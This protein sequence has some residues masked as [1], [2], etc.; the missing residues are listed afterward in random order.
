MATYSS[1]P[2]M[3][4]MNMMAETGLEKYS[5]AWMAEAK[6]LAIKLAEQIRDELLSFTHYDEPAHPEVTFIDRP[7][8]VCIVAKDHLGNEIAGDIAINAYNGFRPEVWDKDHEA[9]SKYARFEEYEV[10]EP[11]V[12]TINDV[13]CHFHMVGHFQQDA[14]ESSRENAFKA[15]AKALMAKNGIDEKRYE[16]RWHIENKDEHIMTLKILDIDDWVVSQNV[17][18]NNR[19]YIIAK[20]GNHDVNGTLEEMVN[21][22]FSI[23]G[24]KQQKQE[25]K[26]VEEPKPVVKQESVAPASRPK[27]AER[28]GTATVNKIKK[29]NLVNNTV[30]EIAAFSSE[31][32]RKIESM[33]HEVGD[34]FMKICSNVPKGNRD[35][36]EQMEAM[37]QMLLANICDKGYIDKMINDRIVYDPFMAG[38]SDIRKA[39]FAL[40]DRRILPEMGKWAL[41]GLKTSDIT[42]A[43]NKYM[44]YLG[45]LAS[46]SKP[47]EEVFGRKIDVR[48][49]VVIP[50]GFVEVIGEANVVGEDGKIHYEAKRIVKINAFDGFGIMRDMLTKYESCTIRGPWIKA[51]VQ[52]SSW[53][54]LKKF[55]KEHGIPCR[56]KDLWGTEWNL[57][58]C[59]IILTESCFKAASLYKRWDVYTNA[60]QEMGHR[61]CVC[62]REHKPKLKGMP[63]QQGQTLLGTAEDAEYFAKHSKLTMVKYEEA[64]EAANLLRGDHKAACKIY[65]AL[66][67]EGHTQMCLQ[68]KWTSKRNDMLGGRIP[69][70]GYNSFI[71]PDM[72]AF[73]EHLF[74]LEIKGVLKPGECSCSA[75]MLGDVD[76]TRSPHLNDAHVVMKN[77]PT[78]FAHKKTPTF[79]INIWDFTTLILRCDY[80]GDHVW[81][82]QDEHLL[83]LIDR[84]HKALATIPV[85]WDVAKAPKGPVNK[86]TIAAFITNLL[87]GSE[88]GIYADTLTKMWNNGYDQEVCDWLTYAGNVLIDAAKHASVK[89][90]KPD[91][92]KQIGKECLPLFAM[93]AKADADRPIGAMHWLG[94]KLEQKNPDGSV[95]V[96]DI[97]AKVKYTGSF[98]DMFSK[99]VDEIVPEHLSV[100]GMDK[101]IFN[102]AE[103]M[104]NEH[105]KL[106][107]GL[108][109]K[110]KYNKETGVYDDAGIVQQLAFRH[111]SEWT[112]LFTTTEAKMHRRE[113]EEA[114]RKQALAELVAYTREVY[115]DYDLSAFTDRQIIDAIYDNVVRTVFCTKMSDGMRTVMMQFFWRV[116]GGKA[117]EVLKGKFGEPDT[118]FDF[119]DDDMDDL[120][121][122]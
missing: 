66:L 108:C 32:T 40:I 118:D 102:P 16:I 55:C 28:S 39:T 83:D 15:E 31:I 47:F 49:I 7:D 8:G 106:I 79:F 121:I 75:A 50:D 33:G 54:E 43:I 82:S 77:V 4:I 92:V 111:S 65:P 117:V 84:T 89:I 35:E 94:G 24:G 74:G 119:D 73:M 71:A 97:P 88:I 101:A 25:A 81:W 103:L 17:T 5:E 67:N 120:D 98:L 93:Y 27:S 44:A 34:V 14:R 64:S 109:K 36:T 3:N 100:K 56:F 48:R 114:C 2:I 23:L 105:R 46:A 70:M 6:N 76:V 41:C 113:W 38:S 87:H 104:I 63:Y 59:D 110:G 10:F 37:A 62:V 45:L 57:D 107:P 52:A 9:A 18:R 96:I 13:A 85:D 99:T 1:T 80:D 95:Q 29:L 26:P 12:C 11:D 58:D 51:F 53:W 78:W 22:M 122:D 68:E 69:E 42:I 19:P 115:K 21:L 116:F 86:K 90:V 60:F 91:A 30:E 20:D 61:I 72:V 112:S